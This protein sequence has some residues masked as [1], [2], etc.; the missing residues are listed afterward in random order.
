MSVNPWSFFPLGIVLPFPGKCSD[1]FSSVKD[2]PG[3]TPLFL[4]G[5]ET[6][7]YYGHLMNTWHTDNV[8]ANT[9]G[10]KIN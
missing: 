8:I 4:Y 1:P 6:M 5:W 9:G 3:G 2:I 10:K 7:I